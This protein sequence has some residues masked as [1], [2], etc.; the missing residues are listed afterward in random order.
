M[1]E[2]FLSRIVR[3]ILC[4]TV[5]DVRRLAGYG[6]AWRSRTSSQFQDVQ[7]PH[8]PVC[9]VPLH[10]CFRNVCICLHLD[11]MARGFDGLGTN[12]SSIP[13]VMRKELAAL[14]HIWMSRDA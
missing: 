3:A 7:V 6:V 12:D 4:C 11:V 2:P 9:L 10:S 5:E 13:Q 14:L 1:V 8:V